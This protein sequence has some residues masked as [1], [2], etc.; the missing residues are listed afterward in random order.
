MVMVLLLRSSMLLCVQTVVVVAALLQSVIA[1]SDD[2][3]PTSSCAEINA[4]APWTDCL[5]QQL[6]DFDQPFPRTGVSFTT[7]DAALQKLFDHAET[8]EAAN[9]VTFAPGLDLLVE[10]GHYNNVWLETQPM[11]GAMYGVRNM[12]LAV[13]NQVGR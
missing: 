10:G 3:P 7:S 8:C 9:S 1:V 5:L 6:P 4:S 13:N 12:T 2:P 11:G